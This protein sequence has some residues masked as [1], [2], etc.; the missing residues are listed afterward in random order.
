MTSGLWQNSVS[1]LLLSSKGRSLKHDPKCVWNL[2]FGMAW[3]KYYKF[4]LEAITNEPLVMAREKGWILASWVTN[5][6]GA[7]WGHFPEPWG[8]ALPCFPGAV[9]NKAD[10]FWC[11]SGKSSYTL[12]LGKEKH[13]K[14]RITAAVFTSL[15]FKMVLLVQRAWLLPL[16]PCSCSTWE[17][18][19]DDPSHSQNSFQCVHLLG[20]CHALLFPVTSCQF[21]PLHASLP[22]ALHQTLINIHVHFPPSI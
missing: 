15:E 3:N 4:L 12:C 17:R 1:Y 16:Y 11:N 20:R 21:T 13:V 2:I 6:S 7:V 8:A 19:A 9:T 18:A 5:S 14:C 10:I 22:A